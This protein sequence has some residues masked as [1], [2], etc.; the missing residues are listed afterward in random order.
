MKITRFNHAAVN[1]HGK[2]DEAREFYTGLLGLPEV[3]IALPGRPPIPK[4]AIQ[5]FWMELDGC[6]VHAI[7]APAKGELREPTGPHVSWYVADLQ[8][9]IDELDAR[10]VEM[11]VLGEGRERIVWIADPAGNTVEFQ[12]DPSC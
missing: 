11:R 7:G 1:I 2:V 5:A 8:L 6:Q 4:G 3:P 12:Q 9:A 10:G